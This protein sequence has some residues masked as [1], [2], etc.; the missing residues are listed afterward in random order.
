M[1]E[2]GYDAAGD[3]DPF[4]YWLD[5]SHPRLDDNADGVGHGKDALSYTDSTKDGYLA[6]HTYL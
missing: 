6:K 2:N 4:M 5:V 3:Y 1:F